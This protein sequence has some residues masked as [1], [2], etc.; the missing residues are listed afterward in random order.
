MPQS[1]PLLWV[2]GANGI[3]LTTWIIAGGGLEHCLFFH[4]LG[5]IIPT[6][7]HICQR[8]WNYQQDC[9]VCV[10]VCQNLSFSMLVGWTPI[11]PSYFDVH[12]GYKVLTQS[13]LSDSVTAL[14]SAQATQLGVA[15]AWYTGDPDRDGKL[16]E[17]GA[18]GTQPWD[19]EP[20]S[21]RP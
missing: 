16:R 19:L 13:H 11:N 20:S 2:G 21:G 17:S 9:H 1:S 5:I 18:L 6:D 14:A 15:A 12:Q 8:V 4:E 7:F 3:V 10:S